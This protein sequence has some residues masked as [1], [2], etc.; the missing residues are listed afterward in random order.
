MAIDW[1]I[2]GAQFSSCNCAYGCPCQFEDL[3]TH[4]DCR[5]FE[6]VQV[7]RGHFGDVKLEGVRFAI[8]YAWP[9]PVFEGGG[10]M[11][12]II[13]E[14]SDAGQRAALSRV[15]QG[16]ETE[17][18]KTHWWVFR[19]MCTTVHPVLFR[20]I[21]CEIDIEARTARASIPG[22]LEATGRPILSPATGQPHR[23]RIDI[24]R[25]IEFEQAEIGSATSRT[26][27]A[28]SMDLN[29]TYGQFNV[30]R[31]TGRGVVHD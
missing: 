11:Q 18:G 21:E 6:V 15:L 29:D 14:R 3:P 27:G 16:E 22:V 13:D 25:G 23:V 9:G 30:L 31:H 24:P 17:E 7:R 10:E 28:I 8:V 1:Y 12:V 2:E 19:A 5:G 4:G 26:T 20:P